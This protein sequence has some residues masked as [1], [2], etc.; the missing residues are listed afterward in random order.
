MRCVSGSHGYLDGSGFYLCEKN[1]S[2]VNQD[3]YHL[4]QWVTEAVFSNS[5]SSIHAVFSFDV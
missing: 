3:E 2:C 4:K 1:H 5:N